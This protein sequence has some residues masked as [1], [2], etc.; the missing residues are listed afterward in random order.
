MWFYR[1]LIFEYILSFVKDMT[2]GR[3]KKMHGVPFLQ[4]FDIFNTQQ[5][6]CSEYFENM[7]K[8]AELPENSDNLLQRL[9]K[10]INRLQNP[11]SAKK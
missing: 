11:Q 6:K 8:S 1:N 7:Q 3:Q 2:K 10:W 5:L 4:F 9:F